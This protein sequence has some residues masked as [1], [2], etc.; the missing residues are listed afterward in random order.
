[1]RL[2]SSDDEIL[3]LPGEGPVATPRDDR[4][5]EGGAEFGYQFRSR[6]RV[7]VSAVYADRQS[8]I[9]TFGISGLLAGLTVTYN[10][11]QP[12]FR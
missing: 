6:I 7:G 10:P 4:V 2:V 1:V 3:V 12:S 11:P 8:N 9:E 5:R